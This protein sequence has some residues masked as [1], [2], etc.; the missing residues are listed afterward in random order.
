MAER[1]PYQLH[2]LKDHD[3]AV[4]LEL[5]QEAY[6]TNDKQQDPQ[7]VGTLRGTQ[8]LACQPGLVEVLKNE[9][10][11][12]SVLTRPRTDPLG[13]TEDT[14]IYLGLLFRLARPLRR[15][16]RIQ[17]VLQG[18]VRMTPDER[19]YFYARVQYSGKGR[20]MERALRLW[21]GEE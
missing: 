9:G 18:L 17:N 13:L 4:R 21:L 11:P 8:F 10:H 5:W 19:Q 14:G 15:V 1:K 16:E 12:P 6:N 3:N 20:Y 7:K 2:I